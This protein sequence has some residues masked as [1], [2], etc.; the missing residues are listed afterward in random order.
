MLSGHGRKETVMAKVVGAEERDKL[1]GLL[2]EYFRQ[3]RQKGGYPYDANRLTAFLQ[4]GIEGRFWSGLFDDVLYRHKLSRAELYQRICMNGSA[5]FEAISE[6]VDTRGKTFSVKKATADKLLEFVGTVKVPATDKFIARNHFVV[7]S[8]ASA[9]V[10]IGLLGDN[11]K[12]WFLNKVEESNGQTELCYHQLRKPSVDKSILQELGD[13]AET[14][15]SQIW[16]LLNLQPRG[17]NGVL[18]TDGYVNI[19][20]VCDASGV[21]RAVYVY[22]HSGYGDWVV[23]AVFVEGPDGWRDGYR[24]FSH[25]S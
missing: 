9:K 10:K 5:F 15:L 1:T 18:L 13:S 20:Y 11:F 17:E 21:L 2:L 22:W 14:T 23:D 25:N 4:E 6:I 8:P 12:L 3:I 16:E 19:F 7:N 24:V